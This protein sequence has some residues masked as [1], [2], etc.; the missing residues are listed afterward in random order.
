MN[1]DKLDFSNSDLVQQ[2]S[3]L[4]SEGINPHTAD[5]DEL[6]TLAMLQKI[7]G[8]DAK[9]AAAVE[10]TLPEIAKAVEAIV[11]SF[12]RG[13]RLIYMGAG[14]SGRLGVLD[15]AECPPTFSVPPEM[16]VGVIAGGETAMFKAVEGAE[17]SA[18]LAATDLQALDLSSK[19]TVIGIAA[20]GRTP[21]AI[22]AVNAARA[23]GAT[24][25][26]VACN[27]DTELL[28]SAHIAICAHVGPEVLAGSTRL[29]SG[30]AQKMVLNMLT[31]ASMI[32]MGKV[33]GNLMVDVNASNEKLRARAIRIIMQSVDCNAQTAQ[34]LLKKANQQLKVAILMGLTGMSPTAAT[35]QLSQAKG[36]IRAAINQHG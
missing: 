31:T 34:T 35:K 20:S 4:S 28:K 19:D 36:V 17:D 2:L 10:K 14:T 12:Q 15:A 11:Q 8:E 21:Y 23:T 16:V 29:K 5:L 25:V 27:P 32:K 30:T 18:E 33:F 13:G 24:T 6:D 3:T 26:G 9:V 7:N 1:A 22:G